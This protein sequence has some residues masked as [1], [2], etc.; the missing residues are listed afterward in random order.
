M[1]KDRDPLIRLATYNVR[2]PVDKEPNDWAHR[3]PRLLALMEKHRFGIVGLQEATKGQIDDLR[4]DGWCYVG[5]A[6]EDGK[7]QGEYACIAYRPE[8]FEV[9]E[10]STFWLSET[11]DVPGSRSW[12]S[13]CTRICTWGRFRDRLTDS[14]FTLFNTHLDHRSKAAQ[15]NG[16]KLILKRIKIIAPEGAV[17]LSGDFNVFPDSPVIAMIDAIMHNVWDISLTPVEG[18]RYTYNAFKYCDEPPASH[19]GPIDYIYVNSSVRVQGV[20]VLNDSEHGLYPS[21]HF[22]VLACLNI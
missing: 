12:E 5:Q 7:E 1:Y 3:L 22:P 4:A 2:C 6:R 10:T 20:R 18:P 15:L 17:I 13:V 11:P 8:R 9:D 19:P 16:M 21:D 14:C